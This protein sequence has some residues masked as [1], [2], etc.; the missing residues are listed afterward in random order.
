MHPVDHLFIF[1]LLVVQPV[2]GWIEFRRFV[3]RIEAGNTANRVK[4]YR[5]TMFLEWMALGVLGISWYLLD[6][7]LSELGFVSP[8]GRGFWLG[9]ACVVLA[10]AYF[11]YAWRQAKSMRQA[12]KIKH[13][14]A[15]GMLRHFVPQNEREFR[16]FTAVSITAGIVEETLYRGFVLW[17]LLQIMPVW[18]AVVASSVIFGLGHTYQGINGVARVTGVGAVLA[19]LFFTTGSIWVPIAAHILL[20]VLQGGIILRIFSNTPDPDPEPAG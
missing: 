3:R 5:Q 1:L 6:R 9:A 16:N 20:D 11:A 8:E 19:L 14:D 12:E 2:H 7:P 18:A 15:L 4:L 17:Y 10:S 13:R